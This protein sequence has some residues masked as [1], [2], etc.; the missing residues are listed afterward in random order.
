MNFRKNRD[1]FIKLLVIFSAT[2]SVGMLVLIIGFI[3]LKGLPILNSDF[4]TRDYNSVTQYIF[5][6]SDKTYSKPD[7]V[8]EGSIYIDKY[9]IAI[10]ES[11]SDDKQKVYEITYVKSDSTVSKALNIANEKYELERL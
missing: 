1:K 4:I 2:I 5:I 10:S 8:P 6:N 3:F 11:F 7:N 9:G